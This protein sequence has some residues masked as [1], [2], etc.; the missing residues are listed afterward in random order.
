MKI[1]AAVPPRP[2]RKRRVARTNLSYNGL[3]SDMAAQQDTW[4]RVPG[5]DVAGATNWKKQ[6]SLS[7]AARRRGYRIETSIQDDVLYARIVTDV[8]NG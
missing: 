8:Q 3:M 4:F 7:Q 2:V 6:N 1:V 5:D